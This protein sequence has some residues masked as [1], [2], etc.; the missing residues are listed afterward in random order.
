MA[1]IVCLPLPEDTN[2][3]GCGVF[4]P[5]AAAVGLSLLLPRRRRQLHTHP[6]HEQELCLLGCICHISPCV[7]CCSCSEDPAGIQA[8]LSMQVLGSSCGVRM[9]DVGQPHPTWHRNRVPGHG[10]LSAITRGVQSTLSPL[11]RSWHAEMPVSSM[12]CPQGWNS[13]C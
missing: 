9:G 8:G 12:A 6:G 3:G 11:G 10:A 4:L 1:V 13:S 5:R 2:N 7:G